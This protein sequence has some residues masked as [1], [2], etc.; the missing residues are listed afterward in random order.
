MP[1]APSDFWD[2]L[3]DATPARIA[4]GRVGDALPTRRVLEFQLAHAKARDAVETA[5]DPA[6]LLAEL[7]HWRP[8]LVRS[9][10]DDRRTFLQRPDLGRRLAPPSAEAL[11]PERPGAYD[12]TIVIADGLSAAA[13][14]TQG[15]PLCKMLLATQGLSFAPPVVALQARVALGDEIAARQ[16]ARMALVLIGERPGLSAC[17]SL[18]AYLTI[19]PAPGA[20][21]DARR[22]C[23][24]NIRPDGLSLEDA[25]RRI[26]ALMF[27]AR[28]LG[29]TG[30]ELKEDDALALEH[31]PNGLVQSV[32]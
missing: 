26:L 28:A 1:R 16:G 17:D 25:S 9:Q 7:A 22:N 18:G 32:R 5:L 11:A 19:D 24:S 4:L 6:P 30:T 15:P 2:Y 14:Q 8:I 12:A 27:A 3:R 23:V 20:T 31:I 13:A 29:L 10:A 21:S